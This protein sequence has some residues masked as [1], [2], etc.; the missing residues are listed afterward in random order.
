[1]NSIPV[2]VQQ[3]IGVAIRVVIVFLAGWLAA[4]GGTSMSES[5]IGHAVEVATPVIIALLW[6]IWTRYG[7]R[8]KLV[9]AIANPQLQTEKEVEAHIADPTKANPSVLTPKDVV[10]TPVPDKP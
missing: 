2:I 8:L 6:G 7:S 5:Q 9:T 10:P 1:M 3:G 4:H